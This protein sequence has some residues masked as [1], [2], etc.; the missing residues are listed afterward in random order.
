LNTPSAIPRNRFW[1]AVTGAPTAFFDSIHERHNEYA[2]AGVLPEFK[3]FINGP[4]G[5]PPHIICASERQPPFKRCL[6]K[7]SEFGRH[8]PLPPLHLAVLL[9]EAL[10]PHDIRHFQP[11]NLAIRW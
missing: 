3:A 5:D 10:Q 4:S 1:S 6:L 8:R 9:P 2:G 11:A 7:P